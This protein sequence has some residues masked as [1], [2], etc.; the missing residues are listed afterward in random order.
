[1]LPNYIESFT[2]KIEVSESRFKLTSEAG[3]KSGEPV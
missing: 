3:T 1:M 2:F